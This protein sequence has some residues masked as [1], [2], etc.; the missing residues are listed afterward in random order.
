MYPGSTC[1]RSRKTQQFYL[2]NEGTVKL[3][4]YIL[5]STPTPVI[6][7]SI[8]A[9]SQPVNTIIINKF[10][11]SNT[12]SRKNIAHSSATVQPLVDRQLLKSYLQLRA[13]P[14][15]VADVL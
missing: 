9:V 7:S 10:N 3:L 11:P 8:T 1:N 2:L 6:A 4:P 13:H 15:V 5:P 12:D 14:P